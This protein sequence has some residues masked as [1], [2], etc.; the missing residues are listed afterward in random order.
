MPNYLV[1]EF[2]ES[3]RL[4]RLF[5]RSAAPRNPIH[6]VWRRSSVE[7]SRFK[8]VREALQGPEPHKPPRRRPVPRRS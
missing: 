3:G 2:V 1:R 5:P 4:L 7:T 8:I 6:L